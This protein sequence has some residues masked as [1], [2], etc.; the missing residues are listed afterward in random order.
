MRRGIDDHDFHGLPESRRAQHQAP[1]RRLHF[2]LFI[3]GQPTTNLRGPVSSLGYSNP[4]ITSRSPI[5]AQ[6]S[7]GPGWFGSGDPSLGNIL[8]GGKLGI[9]NFPCASTAPNKDPICI[10]GLSIPAVALTGTALQP[11]AN[12]T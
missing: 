12:W 7:E 4:W 2:D 8:P 11:C 3:P 5:L 10:R 6:Y 1:N 9:V